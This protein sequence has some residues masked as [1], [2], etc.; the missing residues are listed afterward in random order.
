MI[1]CCHD[2]FPPVIGH[3]RN[4]L[5]VSLVSMVDILRGQL[6]QAR[7]MSLRTHMHNACVMSSFTVLISVLSF[8]QI[9]RLMSAV[10]VFPAV[11]ISVPAAMA[12]MTFSMSAVMRMFFVSP[13]RGVSVIFV[14]GMCMLA[15]M[16]QM[17]FMFL[18]IRMFLHFD[19]Q[20]PSRMFELMLRFCGRI[21]LSFMPFFLVSFAFM[22]S[23]FF[24][25]M[26]LI[27]LFLMSFLCWMI[28][29]TL[30]FFI[31]M[32]IGGMC[33]RNLSIFVLFGRRSFCR[34]RVRFSG[35]L[36]VGDQ[37]R[38]FI[39]HDNSRFFNGSSMSLCSERF[40]H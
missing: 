15:L 12:A 35:V 1:G 21:V 29:F 2:G 20:L 30:L 22:S 40:V 10:C 32:F 7:R 27:F 23:P 16:R 24:R 18:V 3:L 25:R 33:L 6:G 5:V 4:P 14:M 26:L 36:R 38:N 34:G 28:F 9:F 11:V 37:R 8:Q 17:Q 19:Q 39:S 13:V 31:R